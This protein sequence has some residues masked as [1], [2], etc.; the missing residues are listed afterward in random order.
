ME[1][2]GT[3]K[4]T[5]Y[6]KDAK[7]IVL[8]LG[9]KVLL[10]HHNDID[11]G[12]FDRL[13]RDI[14]LL[15]RKGYEFI[16]V[17]S[18][19]VGFGMSC[20]SLD[21]RPEKIKKVQALAAIGQNLLM[22]DWSDIFAAH[23]M[24][25]GQVLLTYAVMQ[26]RNR[27]LHA[28]NCLGAML[29]YGVIPIV[30]ENDAVS[31]DEIKF[32]DNDALSAITALLVDADLLVLFTDTDGVFDKNPQ[33]D[34]TAQRIRFIDKIDDRILGMVND[35]AN[36]YSIG[37]MSSKLTAAKMSQNSGTGVII[38]NGYTPDLLGILNGDDVGTFFKPNK[39]KINGKRK[40]IFFHKKTQGKIIVDNGA[41]KA[42]ITSA[43]SLLPRGI[44]SVEGEFKEGAV[45]GISDG[46][47]ETFA[48]GMTYYS[49]ADITRIKGKKS[50]Q[51]GA[52]LGRTYY[53]EV[54][55]RNNMILL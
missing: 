54:V 11:R 40:W 9:T 42:L 12:R 35:K 41:K 26:D 22:K 2:S 25:A 23:D 43:T 5:K 29:E 28:K 38:A 15:R 44:L 34:P 46:E 8:K 52:I 49:A 45:V 17:S 13:V 24:T 51:I 37:G 20:L 47:G 39:K 3:M 18:G 19:A 55:D 14:A 30:N 27:Y 7:R 21:K 48:R 4:R 32:G 10:S 31:V 33:A 36:G 50:E 16:I 53:D 6:I 1:R